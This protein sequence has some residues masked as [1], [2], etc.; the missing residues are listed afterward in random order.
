MGSAAPL[1]PQ[2]PIGYPLDIAEANRGRVPAAIC[3]PDIAG[4]NG[5]RVD[6]PDPG[7]EAPDQLFPMRLEDE[8][9]VSRTEPAG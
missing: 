2:A 1:N 8:R 9:L 4:A 3:L 7:S 6:Q 5:Q